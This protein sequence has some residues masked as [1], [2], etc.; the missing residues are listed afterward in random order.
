[1]RAGATASKLGRQSGNQTRKDNF[2]HEGTKDTKDTKEEFPRKDAKAAK[3]RNQKTRSTKSEIRNKFKR[4]KNAML[5]TDC[6]G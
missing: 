1:M 2:H 3:E 6:F 4:A 5:Q